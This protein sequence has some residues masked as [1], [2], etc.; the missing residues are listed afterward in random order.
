MPADYEKPEYQ[1]N[2]DKYKSNADKYREAEKKDQPRTRPAD[3]DRTKLPPKPKP[4]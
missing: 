2:V 4:A 1:S 3:S